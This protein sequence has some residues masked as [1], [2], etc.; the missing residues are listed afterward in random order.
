MKKLYTLRQ[1]YLSLFT[2]VFGLLAAIPIQ[3]QTLAFP[4]AEGFGRY[5]TGGRY[6]SVYHV[7]NL[8]NT[9][10]GSLRD[11]VSA[12]DRIVVFDVAGVIR[13]TSRIVVARNIYIAGQ[14]AP[15][16]GITV[17]GNGWSFS[18]ADNTICRYLRIRMGIVGDDGK[19]ANGLAEGH[20]MIFDHCSI[21]WGRDETFSINAAT[22]KNITI[23]NSIMSQGLLTHSAGGLMQAD[24]ITLYRNLYADNSTRNNK[25]KGI[26]QY[27]NNI[28]YNW[29]DGAYIMGGESEGHSYAN[30]INNVFIQ[31]P[32][33]GVA[34]FNLGNL[35][36]HIYASG[37]IHDNNRDGVFNP[38]VIPPAEYAGPPDFQGN[39]YPY[40]TLPTEPA[41]Q[42]VNSLL[43]VVGASLPYRDYADYY[44]VNEVKS[45][46]KKGEHIANENTLPFGAPTG[47]NLWAGNTRIDN[48]NDGMPDAWENAN[49]T[50]AS[51]DD[52]M[53]IHAS[54]YANIERY[55][56]SISGDD[57]QPYLRAPLKLK[58][59]SATQQTIYL[60]WLD[61]TEKEQGY[62]V[63][64]MVNGA[65]TQIGTTGVN[66]SYFAV[67]GLQPEESDTFRVKAFNAGGSSAYSNEFTGKS[68]PV[69]VPVLNP[70][71][72]AAALTWTGAISQDW[73]LITQN[74]RDS[75]LTPKPFTDSSSITFD[76]A[77]GNIHVIAPM[78]AGDML[79][80]SAA[81]YSFAGAGVIS[82]TKSVNKAGS[83]IL[84][85]LT[86]NNYTGA[87]VLHNGTLELNTL[88]NGGVASS[89]GASANY[90]F[91][92]V[93]KGG[94]WL[95]TGP[96]TST[97]RNAV[98]DN[99]SE[100]NVS[101]AATTVT[102][103]GVLTGDGG[104]IKAGPGKL[105]L[106]NANPYAGETIVK[107]GI[108]E[109]NPLSS[110]TLEG[111]IIDNNRGIGTSQVLRLQ[112]GTYKTSGGSNSMYENY[113]L[114]L[115]VEDSTVN[116]FEPYRL[117][118]LS[119]TVHGGGTLNYTIPYLREIIQGDWSDF[120]GTLVAHGIN[121]EE[122]YSLLAIDNNSGFPNNRIVLT[123]NT[124]IA[125]YSNEQVFSIG[126][127]SGNAGTWLS[128]GGTKSPSFGNGIT[129]YIVGGA[130]TDETFNGIINNH[131]Y[132]NAAEGNGT[133]TLVKT[134]IGLWRLN[135]N[136]THAGTTTIEAGKLILN[137]NN[138][139]TG[140]VT[141]AEG[142]TLAGKGA[143][144]AAVEV[145]GLLE[146]GDNSI[147][148]F[149]LKDNLALTSTATTVIDIN[150]NNNTS[151][152]VTVT[153][154]VTYGGT[155][156][157]HFTGTPASGDKFKLFNV[158]GAVQGNITQFIPAT[159]GPGLLWVFKPAIGELAVQSP[160]FV[161]APSNL[162]LS[163]PVAAPGEANTVN[164]TW[165]DNSGNE[166]YFILERSSDNTT[167]I[168]IAHPT[169]NT[170]V[171][172]DGGLQAG[173]TYYYRIKAYK[174]VYSAVA[175]VTTPAAGT[176]P[177][178]A[179]SPLPAT[180]AGNILLNNQPLTLGWSSNYADTYEVY[181]GTDT[182]NL[183]NIGNVAN[184]T[185]TPT[186]LEPNTRY[187]WRID[188]KNGNGTT[189]GA[190]WSFQTANVPKTVAGDYRSAASGNWGT[191]TVSTAIWESFD[192][193]N[194]NSTSVPPNGAVPTVTIRTGHT[195]A[196]NAT[197][198]VNNL[199][200]ENGGTLQ[201]GTSDGGSG[202]ASARNLRVISSVNNFGSVGSSSASANRVNFEG[203]RAEGTIYITGT[204]TFYLNTFTVNALAKTVEVVIDANLNLS[205][206]M[207]ANHSTSTTLPWTSESQN[208]D[209]I[210][211][212]INEGKTV[213]MGSSGYLQAGSSPTTNTI[214]EFGN[215][216]YNI[217]GTL[218]MRSTGTSCVVGHAT[219]PSVT[220]IN[221]NG[222]WLMG[223]AIR[224]ITNA[225]TAPT[226]SVSLNIGNNGVADAGA[227]TIGSSNTATNI[228][229]TNNNFGQVVFFNIEGDGQLKSRVANSAVT[230]YVGAGNA[231]SPVRLTNAGTPDVIGVGVKATVDLPVTD[232]AAIVKRQYN[233]TAPATAN[234]TAA[235]GW[236]P[237]S[238]ASNFSTANA[239]VQ[240]RYDNNTWIESA[241]TL[242]G[243]GTMTNPYYAAAAGHTAFGS[244]IVGQSGAVKDTE[245]PTVR[246]KDL[247]V[248]LGLNG[249]ANITAAQVNDSSSDNS[250]QFTMEVTPSQFATAGIDTVTLTVTDAAGNTATAKALVT[251]QKRAAIIRYTGDSTEQYSDKQVLSAVLTD[252]ETGTLLNGKT[253]RFDLG[254]Q[255]VQSTTD[256]I[257]TGTAALLIAQ[258]PG[259]YALRPVFEGDALFQPAADSSA[260]IIQPEDA[261]ITYTGSTFAGNGSAVTLSAT[262][263][264]ITAETPATDPF[265]GDVTKATISF[266][267]R[268]TQAVIATVPVAPNG[269]ATYTWSVDPGAANAREFTIGVV[270]GVAYQRNASTENTII[271][272]ARNSNGLVTGGGFLQLNR[273]A[274]IKPGDVGSRENFGFHLQYNRST[275]KLEGSYNTI[276]RS[277]QRVYQ[278]KGNTPT[279]LTATPAIGILPAK[280]FFTGKASIHDITDPFAPILVEDN[281]TM[282]VDMT[283]RNATDAIAISV[284]NRNGSLWFASNWYAI[285]NAEQAL[286]G[287]NISINS[288]F[289]LILATLGVTQPDHTTGLNVSLAPNPTS[290]HTNAVIKADPAK[291][292][293]VL[294]VYDAS[295]HLFETKEAV[296]TGS[297]ISI[298]GHYKAGV[299]ILVVTQEGAQQVVKFV[300]Q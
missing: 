43:P 277:N 138:T 52:A 73:D 163:A 2:M 29:K 134:G 285:L 57:S 45:F 54:G 30:A 23:Q 60:S 236:L 176:L 180:G 154:D 179:F 152:V 215:Y 119:M 40:P 164:C 183:V 202:T 88:G 298:G 91:N 184:T 34:P 240:G 280:A 160:D 149:T 53:T 99:S 288:N 72:F 24:S 103:N 66:E 92:W 289:P 161:E 294:H 259:S 283:D 77:G 67:T 260:F 196:L 18:N 252:Q 170:T 79:V 27:V 172:S 59:D 253:I 4:G 281:A 248:T 222:R 16:E 105:V 83:G 266:I 132:G 38:Y 94:S 15:G 162:T 128:C 190:T 175:A 250:G 28:V 55:I 14:T 246:T 68:K 58:Q 233:I 268:S 195:V 139:G 87:T 232:S 33:K 271:T 243:A 13:I 212:T 275:R 5:A 189:V 148:T 269:T 142:A 239:L 168:D 237:V 122:A 178:P 70:S 166:E 125:A 198:A 192:G 3:A 216:T 41:D 81:N 177:V 26:N 90:G 265:A 241:A 109:V 100:F 165:T 137:G 297:P 261:R 228:V 36:Y 256:S 49:G 181:L 242:S 247:A 117:A 155:L 225:T 255:S 204:N 291:G 173:V 19:D 71:T 127:L 186:N 7:T 169:A 35:N 8:N 101:N 6:G 44:V 211:I 217:N 223:N 25:I 51:A 69:E 158:A 293:I 141:V 133:T 182:N 171:Y 221:V 42:L 262:L 300:K 89:I 299:Y 295:G 230:Y 220:T 270:A 272:V 274:G 50:N 95:Y 156:Q 187:F 219:L 254:T 21:S 197:S 112:N 282:F 245:A 107:G 76:G 238:Q 124:K 37:N 276:I 22:A 218:D 257:G 64:R 147:S 123:G 199:V 31:G 111:N 249:V 114:H 290:T 263:R 75:S 48:D 17:Y 56:N 20:D 286:A 224:F 130:G 188:G 258:L 227:R 98:L 226:G 78:V 32:A 136:N 143:V 146:P 65:W 244:F 267:D 200:V 129:T 86:K 235:F 102:F 150:K 231:Y 96:T 151:D 213:S 126:G 61:Y 251:V 205:S 62:A 131:L 118:N 157:L 159:P 278:V 153:K 121:T 284:R 191:S 116:G 174:S 140:K 209:N 74:W 46:G 106:K 208:D 292:R 207:R 10:P 97:D 264:D 1:G 185:F 11:A 39:P 82:G 113:P 85:L 206:Y 203:Y 110:A 145:N 214:G 234:L 120:T 229:V 84:S 9:G 279:L 63:E 287:G 273:S 80:N 296:P 104:L 194:W 93:W 201:S 115:Y 193:S 47:W 135:G 144:S 210:T 167:F 108:L 12:P